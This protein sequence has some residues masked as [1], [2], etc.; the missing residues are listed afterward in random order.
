M[1]VKSTRSGRIKRFDPEKLLQQLAE[2]METDHL[3]RDVNLTIE[4][5]AEKM[6]TNRTYLSRAVNENYQMPFRQ[7]LNAYRIER[8]IQYMLAHP[9]ANQDE[10]AKNSGFLSAS[11]FN[12]KF[13]A[14][15]GTSPRLWLVEM[16]IGGKY[17]GTL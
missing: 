16:S 2:V 8:S 11:S 13:K 6:H 9:A 5:L 15:T 14:I 12:H 4:M 3:Y 7:W 10:I 17:S 1:E